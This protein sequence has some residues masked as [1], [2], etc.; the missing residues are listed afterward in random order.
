MGRSHSAAQST[1]AIDSTSLRRSTGRSGL[2]S[3]PLLQGNVK[4]QSARR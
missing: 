4:A 1:G 3:N 2:K